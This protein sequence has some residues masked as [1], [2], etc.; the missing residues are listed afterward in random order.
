MAT[1]KQAKC[2]ICAQPRPAY[3]MISHRNEEIS[4]HFGF[5]KDCVRELAKRNNGA[6]KTMRLLN[7][8]YIHDLWIRSQNDEPINPF[9][10]YLQ[11]IAPKKMYKNFLDSEYGRLHD[12]RA[13][14]KIT[15]EIVARWGTGSEWTNDRYVEHEM[16][17]DDLKRIKQPATTLEE[18]RY[19]ENV[20]LGKRLQD[21]IENGKATDIRA[22][23]QTY[24]QDLRELGLDIETVSKE[25]TRTLGTRIRDWE[26]SEPL[27]ELSPEFSDVDRIQKYIQKYFL[28]PMKRVFNQATEEEINSLY[29]NDPNIDPEKGDQ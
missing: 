6:M 22:L 23:K 11:L 19:I 5:C 16:A 4:E 20:R 28:I 3:Q 29:H 1:K 8:P 25:D 27:P 26:R 7:I 21:E 2:L 17:L 18:K 14:I 9:S 15:E 24:A 10:R 12:E 13:T